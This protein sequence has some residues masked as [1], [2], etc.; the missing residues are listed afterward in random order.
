MAGE[1][2]FAKLS[3]RW[4]A[5]GAA[6]VDRAAAA[7]G[8]LEH[9]RYSPTRLFGDVTRSLFELGST[10][11]NTYE[12]FRTPGVP[13]LELCL[14]VGGEPALAAPSVPDVGPARGLTVGPF[15]PLDGAVGVLPIQCVEVKH[16]PDRRLLCVRAQAPK[17]SCAGV[18]GRFGGDVWADELPLLHLEIVVD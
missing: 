17:E 2:L 5:L 14:T 6:Y 18:H 3:A 16:E 9:G 1:T 8:D 7:A 15:E 13:T 11:A 10:W 4:T 12:D